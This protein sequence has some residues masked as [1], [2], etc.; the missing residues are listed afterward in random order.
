M[1]GIVLWFTGLSGAGKS[2]IANRLKEINPERVIVIDGDEIRAS[3]GIKNDFS[4]DGIILNNKIMAFIANKLAL[5]G[6]IVVVSAISPYKS[7][8][9]HARRIV[10]DSGSEFYEVF[11]N[12]PLDELKK[13]DVKGY[14]KKIN[15]GEI[16]NFIGVHTPYESPENPEI[17][18]NTHLETIDQSVNKILDKIN[19]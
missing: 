5:F 1:K 15:T 6:K 8:R 12:C 11:I 2:T 4:R 10:L 13:K 18:V 14:Y 9:D 3:L 19:L 7:S 16:T 17:V